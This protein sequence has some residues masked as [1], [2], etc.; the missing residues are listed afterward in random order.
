MSDQDRLRE[1]VEVWWQAVDDFTTLLERVPEEQW[2]TPTDL[3]GWDVRAVAA[4]TAHLE[5]LLAGGRHAEVEIG[6][7]PHVRGDMGRFTEQGVVGRRDRGRDELINEIRE[8]ATTRH[9]ALL[10]DPPADGSAPAPGLF[11]AIGWSTETLLR[12]RPLDVWMH[13]QDVR[14]AIDQPVNLDS[15]AAAHVV[16]YLSEALGLVLAKRAE[17]APGSTLVL[18]VDGFTP[19]AFVVGDDG[20]GSELAEA[21]ADPTVRLSMDP[22]TFVL[23]TGGRRASAGDAVRIEGDA[24][25]GRRVVEQM[26]V[27]P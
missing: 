1:Y 17:A 21:P 14:R 6:D 11:G 18:E 8:S 20:R 7:P 26:A 16:D 25:L 3:P 23:L 19:R 15:P 10:A 27:T 22:E 12:N 2:G 24:D 4:H 5:S 13:E 9:T